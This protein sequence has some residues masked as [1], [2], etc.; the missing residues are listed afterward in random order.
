MTLTLQRLAG[1]YAVVRLAPGEGWPHWATWSRALMSVTRTATE[2][3]V[4]CEQDAVPSEVRA[5]RDFVAFA[6]EGPLD[7]AAV[8]ILARLA[9]PLAAA[10]VPLLAISTFDTDV[11]LVRA[12]SAPE[13]R[14]AWRAAGITVRGD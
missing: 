2:T 13:A 10:G 5:E 9:T 11:L 6:V 12:G 14:A 4:I 7:F 3:S 8:G 1:A